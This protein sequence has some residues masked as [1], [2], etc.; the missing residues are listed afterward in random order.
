L[1]P[2]V[3]FVFTFIVVVLAAQALG[4][5]PDLAVYT[6][7]IFGGLFPDFDHEKYEFILAAILSFACFFFFG[8]NTIGNPAVAFVL[9]A[10]AV[11]VLALVRRRTFT[12]VGYKTAPR[13]KFKK[14]WWS[15]AKTANGLVFVL[16]FAAAAFVLSGRVEITVLAAL[17]YASHSILDWLTYGTDFGIRFLVAWSDV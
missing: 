10:L 13:A 15:E 14:E 2:T 17:A 9:A 3:H 1:G 7:A 12:P 6:I 4:V 16:A 5:E 11:L 8:V